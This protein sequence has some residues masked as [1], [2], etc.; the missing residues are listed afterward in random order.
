MSNATGMYSAIADL[1]LR[2]HTCS[3]TRNQ[4][5][6]TGGFDRVTTT[7]SLYGDGVVGRG[8]D[9]IYDPR[10]HRE[11]Q[12]TVEAFALTGTYT[13]DEFS[14][15][16]DSLNLF[17]GTTPDREADRH[18]RR[19]AL[20]SAGLDL[21]LRQASKSLGDAVGRSYDPVDFVVSTTLGDPPSTDRVETLQEH[22][23]D[24]AFKLDPVPAW[25]PDLISELASTGAVRILDFKGQYENVP[26]AQ[27][28]HPE[29]YEQIVDAFPEALLEDPAVTD[30]TRPLFAN[31]SSRVAWDHPV[32]GTE[33]LEALPFE[34]QHVNIK[35]SRFGSVASLFE[36]IEYCETHGIQMYGGGQYELDVGRGQIQALASLYYPDSPNDVAPRAYNEPELPEL[37]QTSP[38]EPPSEQSG[39]S[40]RPA[41]GGQTPY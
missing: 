9:V 33:T 13:F 39:L 23:S 41:D 14:S 3:A 29:L 4:S 22:D 17:P 16:L 25:T 31:V 37:T 6:T 35:P 27:P 40:W 24:L 11:P 36:T 32:T 1:P 19:W 7:I 18:Y 15:Y 26:V 21:A 5:Q 34:T 12:T 8:E 30:R 20:E 38:L 10:A 28:P 2:I